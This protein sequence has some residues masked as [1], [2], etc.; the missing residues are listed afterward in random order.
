MDKA[1]A[2]QLV[3]SQF[4]ALPA[5]ERKTLDQVLAFAETAASAITFETLGNPHAIVVAWVVREFQ[6]GAAI[7]KAIR[8][9]RR[10][11]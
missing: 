7:N 6:G 4:K 3:I 9:V 8:Q 5:S 2:E 11:E 1:E 10:A